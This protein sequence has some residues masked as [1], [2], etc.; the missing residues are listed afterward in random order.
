MSQTEQFKDLK[1]SIPSIELGGSPV[2]ANSTATASAPAQSSAS[3]GNNASVSY[4]AA[5]PAVQSVDTSFA[6]TA[7]QAAPI[8]TQ[9]AAPLSPYQALTQSHG[10]AQTSTEASSQA[11]VD[12]QVKA[13]AEA[14]PTE[15]HSSAFEPAEIK[16]NMAQ[17]HAHMQEN[18][19]S[20]IQ[21]AAPQP[22]VGGKPSS[23]KKL[24]SY[25]D[26]KN[27][28]KYKRFTPVMAW[29]MCAAHTWPA[30]ILPVGLAIACAAAHTGTVSF[31]VALCLLVICVLMQSAANVFNDYYDYVKGTDDSDADVEE[32][33][34]VLVYNDVNPRDAFNFGAGL[35]IVAF[36]IGIYVIVRAG[37]IPLLIALIGAAF[38][39]MYSSGKTPI[40]YL[41]IGEVTSGFVMGGL[42]PLACYVSLTGSFT[43]LSLLWGL[44]TIIGIALIMMTNNT[45]DIE[46][47]KEASRQTLPVMLGRDTA[48]NVY[49][50]LVYLW[51]LAIVVLVCAYFF[52]GIILLPLMLLSCYPLLKALLSNPLSSKSRVAGMSQICGLNIALGAWYIACILLSMATF[53]I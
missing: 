34:A 26:T 19:P 8:K 46:R 4:V 51:L 41:P 22:R 10:S 13:S 40:S 14:H 38:V 36:A 3:N 24:R 9:A 39:V 33:D 23:L 15:P 12:T 45:C 18:V 21:N 25:D 17:L 6:R 50:A 44:P 49:H 7:H 35:L 37:F 53:A 20:F 52:T 27:V 31:S 43:W 30:A 2:A 42:I 29:N 1:T 48:R 16:A 28:H 47:D 32:S 5:K 11:S